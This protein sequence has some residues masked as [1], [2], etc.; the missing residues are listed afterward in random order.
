MTMTDDPYMELAAAIVKL[1][2]KDYEAA[3]KHCLRCPESRSAKA[4]V[5]KEKKFF[6]SGW[7]E[8]LS[9]VDGPRL[10]KMLEEKVKEDLRKKGGAAR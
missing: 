2:V 1:A 5:E 7:F 10:V 3:Y 8:M 4:A 9:D 6:Y